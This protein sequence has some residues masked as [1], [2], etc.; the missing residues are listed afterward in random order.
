MEREC[1]TPPEEPEANHYADLVRL[2]AAGEAHAEDELYRLFAGGVRLLLRRSIGA[3]R[4]EDEV[5]PLLTMVTEIIR[6]G[7]VREPGRLP[8]LVRTIVRERIRDIKGAPA[9]PL[10]AGD[11]PRT[12]AQDPE[13]QRVMAIL[14]GA[15]PRDREILTRFYAQ[16]QP[17]E[18][19]CRELQITADDVE[20]VKATARAQ[21]GAGWRRA[22]AGAPPARAAAPAHT[23]RILQVEDSESDAA[24]IAR[25]LERAGYT[26]DAARVET[27]D[28]MREALRRQDWD[29]IV[30]DHQ[31]P[32][33]DAPAALQVLQESGRDIPF[34]VVSGTIGHE[35]AVAMMKSGAHDYLLKENLA[36]LA[37]AVERELR[38]AATRRERHEAV[39][40]LR[41]NQERL[42][43]AV[44]A[45]QLG[46][47][48]FYPGAGKLV[49]SEC[50][51]RQLGLPADATVD[52]DVFLLSLHP[53]D[54]ERVDRLIQ[55]ALKPEGGGQFAAEYRTVGV[56]DGK[57]RWLASSGHVFFDDGGAPLRLIGVTLD[58][59][60]RRRLLEDLRQLQKLESMGRVAGGVA[61]D[62][63]NLLTV[64]GGGTQVAAD[65]MV[66]GDPLRETMH[67]VLRAV[68]RA[69]E[70]T[71]QL[72][73]FSRRQ[74]HAPRPILL[75]GFLRELEK[76]LRRQIG[77][78]RELV[79]MLDE[80]AGMLHADPLHLRQVLRNLTANAKDAMPGGGRLVIA[81]S[82]CLVDEL[83]ASRR[84]VPS[85][86]YV[87]LSVSDTGKGMAPEQQAQAFE[88]FFTT[89][90]A[91]Q[92][93]GLG[94][95]TV[96]G[97]V[98]QSGGAIWVE[99]QP[100]LGATFT[101]LFP[102]VEGE[103]GLKQPLSA[104]FNE[105]SER[106]PILRN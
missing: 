56:V 67:Q 88:P 82:R 81:T 23:L 2:V 19:I 35:T 98:K 95:A 32:E 27:A 26:L 94:L 52:Y 36:R 47:F 15:T 68:M 100:G 75:N 43:L 60:E 10:P 71:Q 37:P 20:I 79:L 59:T 96:Y 18:Q 4:A 61:H 66:S 8:R 38:E 77:E 9:G 42:A 11:G 105:P 89:K 76:M 21:R 16:L 46:A 101:M 40:A 13:Q 39:R 87:A 57:Q 90:E 50:A 51:K 44:T 62:F 25:L 86:N 7:T 12:P 102:A 106:E 92:G 74:V 3:A 99:S 73:T 41:E 6:A 97:I 48:D 84:G 33:F 58:D 24:L 91:G 70:L 5:R 78:G 31:L 55:H 65:A 104:D 49:L 34:L 69:G 85:G 103:R 28:G 30:S 1:G 93:T 22:L 53:P 63:N 17:V 29:V 45:A 83:L 72:L 54:R 14:R 80:N 64:I